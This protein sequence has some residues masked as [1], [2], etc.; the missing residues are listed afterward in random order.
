MREILIKDEKD[1]KIFAEKTAK[2][3]KVGDI[4]ALFGDLGTGK[5]TFTKYFAK[6]L[7]IDED[8]KSPTFNILLEYE[9]GKI[10]LYHFDLYRLNDSEELFEIG[11]EDYFFGSG[12]CVVKWPEKGGDLIPENAKK[13]YMNYGK[14]EGERI[15]RCTF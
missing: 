7:G 9:G 6:A 1:V 10:P 15:Y 13:I 12:V 8:V 3:V 11:Y 14:E 5:T 2:S 4:I